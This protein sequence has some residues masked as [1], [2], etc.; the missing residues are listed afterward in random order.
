[1]A[2]ELCLRRRGN[3]PPHAIVRRIADHEN[4][5][6]RQDVG[7]DVRDDLVTEVFDRFDVGTVLEV[8]DEEQTLTLVERSRTAFFPLRDRNPR[9][10]ARV[11]DEVAHQRGLLLGYG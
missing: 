10:E 8:A 2:V 5:M 7:I 1:P 6:P 3:R 4:R 11:A 9:P